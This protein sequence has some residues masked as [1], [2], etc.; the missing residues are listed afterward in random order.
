MNTLFFLGGDSR[1]R[2]PLEQTSGSI[3]EGSELSHFLVRAYGA[4]L[5][6][7][8]PADVYFNRN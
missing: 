8:C 4:A 7:Q 3:N 2:L 5:D 1:S 6:H